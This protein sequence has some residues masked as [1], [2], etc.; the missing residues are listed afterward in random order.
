MELSV[1]AG[2]HYDGRFAKR[3]RLGQAGADGDRFCPIRADLVQDLVAV[4]QR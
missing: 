2:L 4:V 1:T 3:S